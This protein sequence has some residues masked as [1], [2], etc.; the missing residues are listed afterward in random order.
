MTE[1]NQGN[2]TLNVS[3]A[4]LKEQADVT[5]DKIKE[6]TEVFE[7]LEEIISRTS[8]YWNGEAGDYYRTLYGENK[9]EIEGILKRLREHPGKL[10]QAAGI[11]ED[12]QPEETTTS[13]LP[14][15]VIL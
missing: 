1:G 2:L 8:H 5:S 11:Y 13:P 7:E 3:A 6:T 14:G 9:E 12:E 4:R 10:L 15:D